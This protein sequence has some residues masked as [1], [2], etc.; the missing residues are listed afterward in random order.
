MLLVLRYVLRVWGRIAPQQRDLVLENIA[1]RH[2]LEVLTR[3]RRRPALQP[4]DRL[5][6]S[7]LSRVWPAW[8]Q[9]LVIV[10]PDTVVRWHRAGWRR[11]W[12]WRSRAPRRGRPRIDAEIAAEIRRMTTE[13][14]RWG[15]MRVLG[16]L[17]KLDFRVSLQT[18]RRYRKDVPRDP[19]SRWRT[20]LENHRPEIWASDF[21]TVHTLWFQTLYVFFFIAHDRRTVM[22]FNVTEL[23]SAPW[24]WRQLIEATPW[25]Q[26]PR[27]LIRDRDRAY[28]GDF[29]ARAK[30]IGIRT[31]LTP[32]ATPQAN[33]IAERLVGTL[34]RECLD[35][36]IVVNERHLRYVLR[37]FVCHYNTA[38]PHQ[39]LELEAPEPGRG[40]PGVKSGPIVSRP[41]LGG[42]THEYER[43]AA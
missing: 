1:L 13:N 30:R 23:P 43:K 15:H 24:V 26:E 7:L 33:G 28:G 31:V 35:H 40:P 6:W 12:K 11:Y 36:L 32:I 21:F 17:R 25:G 2:Q 38:R 20:F 8:R 27:Y 42:L 3:A 37:E 29:V 9:H 19:P 22:H 14:P 18:V 39:A 5:L 41:V 4:G 16:E 34:R 10:Q